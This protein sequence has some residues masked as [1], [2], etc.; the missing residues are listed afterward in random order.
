MK[1]FYNVMFLLASIGLFILSTHI[2]S[3][4]LES[5]TNKKVK[6]MFN[7]ISNR[8]LPNV[9]IG[10][11]TTAIVQS[12]AATTVMTIG[13]VNGSIITLLQASYIIMGANIGTTITAQIAALQSYSFTDIFLVFTFVGV[14]M[15]VLS[16]SDFVKKIGYTLV[17]LGLIFFSIKCMT[18]SI[19]SLKDSQVFVDVLTSIK[20]PVLLLLVGIVITAIIQSSTVMTGILIAIVAN[21]LTIGNGGNSILY[22]ILGTNIGTCI[23][24][25]LASIGATSNGKRTALI[26][27]MF[28]VIGSFIFF[29]FLIIY[30]GFMVDVLARL[31]KSETTQIAMFHTLFNVVTTLVLL[32]FA[33]CLVKLATTIIKDKK[34]PKTSLKYLDERLLKT[35]SVAVS[36][37]VKEICYLYNEA[38]KSLMLTCEDLLGKKTENFKKIEEIKKE[39]SNSNILLTDFLIKLSN[40]KL[41]ERELVKVSSLHHVISDIDRISDL[42]VGIGRCNEGIEKEN[43]EFSLNAYQ[44]IKAMFDKLWILS[45]SALNTFYKQD[46]KSLEKT[47]IIEN[48]LDDLRKKSVDNHIKRL[49]T[50]ECSLLSGGVYER[51]VND[52]ERAGDHLTF[53]AR[54]IIEV[55]HIN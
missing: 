38:K 7:K 32:P 1:T 35:P 18:L 36:L 44:D 52:I 48:E 42:S 22:I 11:A 46:K 28:N 5:L 12:S 47:E 23:S 19:S 21:G 51:I 33:S 10:V 3:E 37:T 41:S 29:I 14:L 55:A 2:I 25:I 54:S 26:H 24:A 40:S 6:S 50:N 8:K 17:G 27:L 34:E 53:I 16:K 49:S 13:L 4:G 20:N 43:I 30:Q 45:E 15:Y 9:G 31:F 39:I